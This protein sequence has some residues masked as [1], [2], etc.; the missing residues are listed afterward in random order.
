MT[1]KSIAVVFLF[2]TSALDS[3]PW[4][5]PLSGVGDGLMALAV[6]LLRRARGLPLLG[7]GAGRRP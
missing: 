7:P 1:T 5:V 2:L 6:V 3:V 4:V